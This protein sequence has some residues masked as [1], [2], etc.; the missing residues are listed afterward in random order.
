MQWQ[1]AL[2]PFFSHL[3]KKK[4]N[5]TKLLAD[6]KTI[7]FPQVIMINLCYRSEPGI[8]PTFKLPGVVIYIPQSTL[9]LN[10]K[11]THQSQPQ[12]H[13]QVINNLGEVYVY[14]S[15]VSGMADRKVS[16]KKKKKKLMEHLAC[17]ISISEDSYYLIQL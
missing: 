8:I 14:M 2:H 13:E 11:T 5:K 3:G 17:Y 15:L 12:G 1:R 6:G 4:Q 7:F 9:S 16:G 10:I